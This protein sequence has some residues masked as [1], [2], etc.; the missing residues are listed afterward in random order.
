[1]SLVF[2]VRRMMS[3]VD[4][5]FLPRNKG[6]F[7]GKDSLLGS[8]RGILEDGMVVNERD[9]MVVDERYSKC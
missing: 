2:A 5:G 7:D 3:R 1:M 4:A 6:I 9:G 8:A